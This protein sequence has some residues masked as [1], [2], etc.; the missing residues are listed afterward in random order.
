LLQAPESYR[1]PRLELV[2][3]L[4]RLREHPSI[5]EIA[6]YYVEHRLVPSTTLADALHLAYCSY[7]AVAFLLTWNCRHLAN[8]NKARHLAVLNGRLGLSVPIVTTPLNLMP[9]ADA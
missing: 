3:G 2:S 5:I 1:T 7:Y 8:A 4:E 6:E 9:E